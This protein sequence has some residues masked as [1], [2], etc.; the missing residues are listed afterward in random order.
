MEFSPDQIELRK[1]FNKVRTLLEKNFTDEEREALVKTEEKP[2]NTVRETLDAFKV[3]IGDEHYAALAGGQAFS[4]ILDRW[5]TARRDARIDQI[6]ER[7]QEKLPEGER[8]R[9]TKGD[10]QQFLVIVAMV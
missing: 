4:D 7:L 9:I 1:T 2:I 3:H 8:S 5:I 6:W 10:L